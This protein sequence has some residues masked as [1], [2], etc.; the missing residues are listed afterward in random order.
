M[1]AVSSRGW[2]QLWDLEKGYWPVCVTPKMSFGL[3]LHHCRI[4]D[5]TSLS[6]S[7]EFPQRNR[8]AEFVYR[9]RGSQ[10]GPVVK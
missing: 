3:L 4:L 1:K 2:G 8:E 6:N 10:R 5:P 9:L 7:P